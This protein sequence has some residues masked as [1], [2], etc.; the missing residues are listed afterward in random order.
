MSDDDYEQRLEAAGRAR[1]TAFQ[2]MGEVGDYVL[3]PLVNPML[4]GGPAW[5]CRP[6]WR[7]IRRPNGNLLIASDGLSDPWED[8]EGPANGYGLEVYMETSDELMPAGLNSDEALG[9]AKSTWLFAAVHEVSQTVAGHGAVRPL[10]EQLGTISVEV[11]GADF[12]EELRNEHGRVGVLLGVPAADVATTV[13]LAEGDL[14][15]LPI[16]LLTVRE[17]DHIVTG[18]EEGRASVASKL[19]AATGHVSST[20][21]ASVI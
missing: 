1:Q 6:A 9:Q 13:D 11:S 14:R 3:A 20:S 21:R 17:L 16:T 19:A 15:L 2:A 7:V 12:P 18:G 8:P 10:L 5:P 4:T